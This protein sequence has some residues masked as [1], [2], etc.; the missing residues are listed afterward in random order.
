[1]HE[2]C[3]NLGNFS[4]KYHCNVAAVRK[5]ATYCF[6]LYKKNVLFTAFHPRDAAARCLPL[7]IAIGKFKAEN[8]SYSGQLMNSV[9]WGGAS[10]NALVGKMLH[11]KLASWM[12]KATLHYRQRVV[13]LN[14]SLKVKE[15][16]MH[17][18]NQEVQ[19][20]LRAVRRCNE[21]GSEDPTRII[22]SVEYG[23]M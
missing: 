19:L 17:Q 11:E 15:T 20:Y 22:Q 2:V 14:V 18:L 16:E 12:S 8:F 3:L 9:R 7:F 6:M 13:F 1:M 4:C 21:D 10:D 5:H 23:F